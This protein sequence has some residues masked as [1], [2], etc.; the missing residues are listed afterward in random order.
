MRINRKLLLL[1]ISFGIIGVVAII[2][3]QA[4]SR[5]SSSGNSSSVT[6]KAIPDD[7]T[8]KV[9]GVVIDNR[10]VTFSKNKNYSFTAA[11]QDF[12]NDT[13]MVNGNDLQ[14]GQ[15]I[16]LLPEAKSDAAVQWTTTHRSAQQERERLGGVEATIAQ[17][18]IDKY[19]PVAKKLPYSTLEYRID[20]Y[21]PIANANKG[22]YITYGKT[23]DFSVTLYPPLAVGDPGSDEYTSWT[24]KAHESVNNFLSDNSVDLS[25]AHITYKSEY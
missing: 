12:E 14:P 13:C 15:T 10:N 24:G 5:S 7:S 25:K 4:R 11:R 19:N 3:A 2:G 9:N 21:D 18:N 17:E 6:L 1:I 22:C 23:I 8:L 20:Y 16:Y